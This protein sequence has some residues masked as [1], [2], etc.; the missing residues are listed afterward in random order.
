MSNATVGWNYSDTDTPIEK[1][2]PVTVDDR[3]GVVEEV[4][5]PGSREARNYYCED[6]GGL[7]VRF[8]D[9][10]LEL[11]PFG[12]HHRIARRRTPPTEQK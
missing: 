7:L 3:P 5:M 8:E 11:L 6:T 4:C 12:H 9:G 2:H 10:L 1:G